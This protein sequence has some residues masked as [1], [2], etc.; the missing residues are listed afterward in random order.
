MTRGSASAAAV[1][2]FVS[3]L[4][5]ERPAIVQ[6]WLYHADLLGL[7]ALPFSRASVVWNIRSAW[8]QGLTRMTTRWCARLS[9]LPAAVVVNSEAGRR[10]HEAI[11][12]HPRRWCLIGNGF[13]LGVFKPDEQARVSLRAELGLASGTPLVGLVGRWDQH[14]DHA[15]FLAGAMRLKAVHPDVHF[16]LAGDGISYDNPLLSSRVA[17]LG[18]AN[19]VHL[20]GNRC[21]AMSAA[22]PCVVTDVGDSAMLVDDPA[23]VVPSGNAETLACAWSRVLSMDPGSRREIGMKARARIAQHYS[24]PAIVKQYETLYEDL[25]C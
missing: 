24:L 10:V 2:R 1:W 13:D 8:H 25:L 11:G 7:T 12:Y 15:T 14:K 17:D 20:L 23:M 19:Y 5:N 6:T 4:R 9:P 21:E 16:V 22:V 18:L 3:L